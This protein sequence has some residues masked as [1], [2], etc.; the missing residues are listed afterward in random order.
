MTFNQIADW[1]NEREYK[2]PRKCVFKGTHVFSILKKRRLREQR[3]NK[4]Y[5]LTLSDWYEEDAD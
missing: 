3:N 5:E 4:P 2:T 1:L